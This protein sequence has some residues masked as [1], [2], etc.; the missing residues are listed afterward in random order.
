MVVY[1][2][3][4]EEQRVEQFEQETTIDVVYRDD[5]YVAVNKPPGLMVHRAKQTPKEEPILLQLVRDQ[6]GS[7]LYPAHR[8]DRPTSGIVIFGLQSD[9]AARLVK[10]FTRREVSKT[11]LALVRGFTPQSGAIDL[12]LR[13]RF[14]DDQ[15]DY[16][17]ECHP[18]QDAH[19]DYQ[20]KKWYELPWPQ[21]K[22]STSRYALI[23]AMPKTGRWHQIRRH[24]K[25]IAH[26]IVGDYRHGD[27]WHNLKFESDLGLNRMLL[28]AI[29][30]QFIHPY[31][32][33]E[34][35]IESSPGVN[36]EKVL[37]GME[38]FEVPFDESQIPPEVQIDVDCKSVNDLP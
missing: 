30:L 20:M 16:D 25:H 12:P 19:T 24:L 28:S 3:R 33:E 34:M 26:P 22:F 1:C 11:Y 31:T 10:L 37:Q 18:M 15:P 9:A 17:P 29:R 13:D 6:I 32:L 27:P 14:G 38:P 7:F 8:L 2:K 36:F 5:Y 21:Q 35:T 23:E 4:S